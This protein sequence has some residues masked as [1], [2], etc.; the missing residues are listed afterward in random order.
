MAT[1][2]VD[3]I[4][5]TEV[6]SSFLFEQDLRFPCERKLG[7]PQSRIASPITDRFQVIESKRPFL[8]VIV[9]RCVEL[10][11]EATNPIRSDRIKLW[12]EEIISDLH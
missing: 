9:E 7:V 3:R 12:F 4:A 1:R 11:I 10:T 2:Y 5:Q 6:N 8:K